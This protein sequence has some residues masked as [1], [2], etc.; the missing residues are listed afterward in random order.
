MLNRKTFSILL[1]LLIHGSLI[2]NNDLVDSNTRID[3]QFQSFIQN[4]IDTALLSSNFSY[5]DSS[6]LSR[7]QSTLELVKKVA[8]TKTRFNYYAKLLNKNIGIGYKPEI[9]LIIDSL[10]DYYQNRHSRTQLA[11][12]YLLGTDFLNPDNPDQIHYYFTS[13]KHIFEEVK[14]TSGLIKAYNSHGYFYWHSSD[15]PK[16]VRNYK[17]ALKY[18]DS[19]DKKPSIGIITNNLGIIFLN[20][21]DYS[22][23]LEYFEISLKNRKAINDY[24]GQLIVLNN[25]GRTYLGLSDTTKALEYLTKTEELLDS[26]K[27]YNA[28]A[29]S[30]NTLA[31]IY[32]HRNKL[33]SAQIVVKKSILN[34]KKSDNLSG[35]LAAMLVKAEVYLNYQRY[36]KSLIVIDSVYNS[37]VEHK[38]NQIIAKSIILRGDNLYK[39][40]AYS[41]A[42]KHYNDALKVSKENRLRNLSLDLYSKISETYN[43]LGE[44]E[45][46]FTYYKNYSSLLN[47]I[48]NEELETKLK[49]IKFQSDLAKQEELNK[50][51]TNENQKLNDALFAR[52]LIGAFMFIILAIAIYLLIAFAINRKKLAKNNRILLKQKRDIDQRRK[53]TKDII[54]N[55]P[56]PFISVEREKRKAHSYNNAFIQFHGYE[57]D[58]F[59]EIA[60]DEI[61]GADKNLDDINKL[62]NTPRQLVFEHEILTLKNKTKKNCLVYAHPIEYSGST[63]I[64]IT[65]VDIT[66]IVLTQIETEKK[67]KQLNSLYILANTIHTETKIENIFNNVL[68]MICNKNIFEECQ[69]GKINFDDKVFQTESSTP[70]HHSIYSDIVI[71]DSVRGKIEIFF[72]NAI[73]TKEFNNYNNLVASLSQLLSTRIQRNIAEDELLSAKEDAEQAR[74]AA[75]AATKAK[76]QFLA[77]M[78]HEIRTPM[79]A[80][81]GLS[82]LTLKTQLNSKQFDYLNK[83]EKSAHALLGIINDIL[84][85]SKIEAGKLE[86]EFT[87]FDLYNVMDTITVINAQKAFDKGLEFVISIA[88]DVPT[89]LIGDQL[90]ISQ[91]ITNFANNAVKFTSEG[92]IFIYVEK[93]RKEQNTI[94]LK[95]SVSDTGIGLTKKQLDKL[96]TAFQQA[97]SSTTR[98]YGGTGLG[99]TISKR[100]ANLMNGDVGA[101]SKE[102]EGSTFYFT[103]D[104]QI[105]DSYLKNEF[106]LEDDIRG[107]KA[108]VCDDNLT[109]Q[110][111]IAQFL[112][113][114]SFEVTQVAKFE[115]VL[116]LIEHDTVSKPEII[117]ISIKV[118]EMDGISLVEELNKLNKQN[119]IK[120]VLLIPYGTEEQ[121][122]KLDTVNYNGILTKPVSPSSLF[123][124]IMEVSGKKIRHAKRLEKGQKFL[125]DIKSLGGAKVLLF[126]DNEINQ[127]VAYELLTDAG[128]NVTI[129]NHGK[130]GVEILANNP[131]DEFNVILMDLQMP[132]MDGYSATKNIREKAKYDEI[133]ILAMTADAMLGVKDKCVE[134]GMQDFITKPID[135]DELF[136]TIVKWVK[137]GSIKDPKIVEVNTKEEEKFPIPD[138][139]GLNVVEGIHRVGNNLK[140]YKTLLEKFA[141]NYTS[142]RDEINEA[143]SSNDIELAIRLAHTLKGVAGN[144]GAK[145]LNRS[146]AKLEKEIKNGGKIEIINEYIEKT[147]NSLN[148]LTES[149]KKVLHITDKKSEYNDIPRAEIKNLLVKLKKSVSE[150]DADSL[151]L[152]KKIGKV[153]GMEFELERIESK[154]NDYDFEEALEVVEDI[155]IKFGE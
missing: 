49:N 36:Y 77:T 100:L 116:K 5:E 44:Y 130:H 132:V 67:S 81:I 97:D 143:L 82:N 122:L 110:T 46:A 138:I 88:P 91:I 50:A 57:P 117:F 149:I 16:A 69:F 150:Y 10:I 131:D 42:L 52:N 15:F 9:K 107:L 73:D 2:A 151:Q 85:F 80:I 128:F 35:L 83:I 6:S 58:G 26:V 123:N 51:L 124:K 78:S 66:E 59:H 90:R 140:L 118:P 106:E 70:T 147:Y 120:I 121:D 144:I 8:S 109:S 55:L 125:E 71:N 92:D 28:I 94:T 31:K 87:E 96:F 145:S 13:A 84:D 134:I 111:I 62:L 14:D 79:N 152:L 113:R 21:A 136:G 29:Y 68:K 1:L 141:N 146:A 142:F 45:K 11:E 39:Q 119:N 104:F 40:F 155:L 139:E 37:A 89:K 126:E 76:S 75:E 22:D 60:I 19:I 129:A 27:D 114:F 74:E 108:I 61:L 17:L 54:D 18:A 32:L 3:T 101:I 34:Y 137:P 53:L 115:N 24:R 86:L 135:P 41:N 25:I 105:A 56:I 48:R 47:D 43:K 99:L 153:K 98:K 127:Q 30:Y 93:I 102:G 20:M 72:R 38:D 4:E 23:A 64:I 95:F 63:R 12:T 103:A 154:L 148:I 65:F 112:E 133:P 7:F 33:D